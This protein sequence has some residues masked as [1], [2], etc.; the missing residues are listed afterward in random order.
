MSEYHG[1]THRPKAQGGTDPIPGLAGSWEWAE[2]NSW[3]Y[4]SANGPIPTDT[5][6]PVAVGADS[7]GLSLDGG[8]QSSFVSSGFV[9]SVD[10]SGDGYAHGILMPSESMCFAIGWVQFNEDFA[11]G[12][13]AGAAINSGGG[14]RI[15]NT[16]PCDGAGS[17]PGVRFSICAPVG[18]DVVLGSTGAILEVYHHSSG[19]KTLRDAQLYVFQFSPDFATA[20]QTNYP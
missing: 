17:A 5:W 10:A 12:D 13:V 19:D 11:D 8:F 3:T 7:G 1:W 15:F 20:V 4:R 14:N 6:T 9:G 16:I 2:L 18:G